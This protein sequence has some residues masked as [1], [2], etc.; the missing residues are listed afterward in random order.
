MLTVKS[1]IVK[2]DSFL[3]YFGPFFMI[4]LIKFYAFAVSLEK[5][6]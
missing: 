3:S 1:G 2:H 4:K 5:E 6:A